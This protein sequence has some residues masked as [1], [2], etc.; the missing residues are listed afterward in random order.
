MGRVIEVLI[1][2]AL[3]LLAHGRK[4]EALVTLER[5]LRLGEPEG[6]I[7]TFVDEGVSMAALLQQ[8]HASSSV[9]A[10]VAKLLAA[11][12]DDDKETRRPGDQETGARPDGTISLSPNL[13]VSRSLVEPLTARELEVL[14]LLAGGASND[15][16][17]RRLIVSLGTVKKHISNIFGKL[18]VESRTQAVA[19]ARALGLL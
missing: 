19:R 4:A 5:A 1:L 3:A 7:R 2:Q 18:E 16:I 9:P 6:Y 13:P 15:E 10:Y 12:P 11:F 8:A 17:A 14:G